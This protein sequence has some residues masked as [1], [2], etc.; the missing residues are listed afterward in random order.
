MTTSPEW[1]L[2]SINGGHVY[3]CNSNTSADE[4]VIHVNIFFQIFQILNVSVVHPIVHL[5]KRCLYF[6]ICVPCTIHAISSFVKNK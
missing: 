4:S 5:M 2:P 6:Y 3:S 1:T